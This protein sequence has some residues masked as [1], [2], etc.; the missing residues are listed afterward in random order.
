MP[1]LLTNLASEVCSS[2]LRCLEDDG[3]FGVSCGL[4][5]SDDGRGGGYVLEI[6]VSH[7]SIML[8][9]ELLRWPEWRI[10]VPVRIWTEPG[11]R[12]QRWHPPFEKERP[13]HPC[14]RFLGGALEVWLEEIASCSW[15]NST[16]VR[17][18]ALTLTARQGNKGN[19][20]QMRFKWENGLP[21]CVVETNGFCVELEEGQKPNLWLN[22]GSSGLGLVG[23]FSVWMRSAASDVL[24]WSQPCPPISP[25]MLFDSTR[26]RCGISRNQPLQRLQHSPRSRHTLSPHHWSLGS[27]SPNK[28]Q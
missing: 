23:F 27:I 14:W 1:I 18:A 6:T 7:A 12:H 5:C 2:S 10:G 20:D 24:I 11:H 8:A 25:S 4:Q 13:W 16:S 21:A 22:A 28:P 3:S 15:R 17:R 9:A 26:R 19:L